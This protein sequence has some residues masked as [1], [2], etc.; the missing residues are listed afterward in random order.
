[1]ITLKENMD[2][3]E[4]ISTLEDNWN[5]YGAKPIPKNLIKLVGNMLHKLSDQPEIFPTASETIQLEYNTEAGDY[6]EFEVLNE[7]NV[8]CYV[9]DRY[10]RQLNYNF[11]PENINEEYNKII[12][13]VNNGGKYAIHILL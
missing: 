11:K 2:K 5:L 10:E 9:L 6:I 12:D 1:M 3:L 8:K 4:L 7:L 13:F